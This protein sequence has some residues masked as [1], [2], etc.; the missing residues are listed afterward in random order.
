MGE[1]QPKE[2]ILAI[3]AEPDWSVVPYDINDVPAAAHSHV[4]DHRR[5]IDHFMERV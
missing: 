3:S 1:D 4:R 5:A 2:F